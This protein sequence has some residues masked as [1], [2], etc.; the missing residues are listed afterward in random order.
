[1]RSGKKNAVVDIYRTTE[2]RHPVTNNPVKTPVLWKGE[3]F[4]D[5][6]PRRGRELAVEGQI[7]A[8]TYMKFDFEFFDVEG[9]TE[10][11]YIVHEGRA[12]DI[13]AVLRDESLKDWTSVDAVT[14]PTNTGRG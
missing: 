5:M 11:M 14:R 3:V 12:Y 1:M 2:T 8:E 6:T 10:E 13:K 4:C 7:T 9:I